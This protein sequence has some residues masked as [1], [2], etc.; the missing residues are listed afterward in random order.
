VAIL[1]LIEK[2]PSLP[3][4]HPP[5]AARFNF[6][7]WMVAHTMLANH[8]YVT[9][10][11]KEERGEILCGIDV[12][13]LESRERERERERDHESYKGS[14]LTVRTYRYR[15]VSL[16]SCRYATSFIIAVAPNTALPIASRFSSIVTSEG[17]VTGGG[18]ERGDSRRN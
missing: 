12:A 13:V 18:Q 16:P 10:R 3:P 8:T 14:I 7:A 6:R 11:R 2:L 9:T 17:G 5:S 15:N 4:P 1:P